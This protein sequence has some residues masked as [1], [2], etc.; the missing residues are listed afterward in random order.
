MN[1]APPARRPVLGREWLL[2]LRPRSTEGPIAALSSPAAVEEAVVLLGEGPVRWAV[3]VGH[4]VAATIV[5]EIPVFGEG[6][7]P[8][9]TLRR[10]TESSTLRSMVLLSCPSAG[11]D[12][13]TEEALEADREFV[14]RGITLDKVMR[15]IRL[16]HAGMAQAFL[17]ACERLAPADRLADEMKAVSEELFHFIDGFSDS[18]VIEF[19]AERDR[20]VTSAAA[21]RAETVRKVLN[22]EGDARAA[23]AALGYDLDRTHLAVIAWPGPGEDASELERDALAELHRAGATA[24]LAVPVGGSAVWAWGTLVRGSV[25][26]EPRTGVPRTHL[27]RGLPAHGVEGFRRTHLQARRAERLARLA[28]ERAAQTTDYDAVSVVSLLAEDLASAREFT[29]RELGALA[30]RTDQA[31]TLRRTVL[32]YLDEE[33]SITTVAG[34]MHVARGTVAYRVRRAEELL[35]REV[36]ERRFALHAALL[37]AESL[38]E[39]VLAEDPA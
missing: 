10:G 14:R 35:G 33:R 34:M 20:W 27:A 1:V 13:I 31:R 15:G 18:M 17:S 26:P 3:E 4:E 8:L 39:V 38:G 24:T 9:H 32:N 21:A 12:A 25:P 23:S 6:V 11:V 36:G 5:R 29:V 16:G 7:G 2:T 19:L 30:A 22:G 28:G 37:L